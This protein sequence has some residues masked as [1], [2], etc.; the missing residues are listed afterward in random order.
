MAKQTLNEHLVTYYERKQLSELTLANLNAIIEESGEG[1]RKRWNRFR[2][3][4]P[5][6]RRFL[7]PGVLAYASVLI[8][9]GYIA[10][11]VTDEPGRDGVPVNL[12]KDIA[13]EIA[14]NHRKLLAVE[15][16]SETIPDLSQQMSKLD[17]SL[18]RPGRLSEAL[19]IVGARYC[20]IQGA[21]AAQIQLTDA[22]GHPYTLYQTRI[23]A[24]LTSIQEET[25]EFE[26]L[27]LKLWHEN[28]IFL[29]LA[30]PEA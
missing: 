6:L 18:I 12:S 30:G 28:G 8:L 5:P 24:P 11:M 3:S 13:R 9:L 16:I 17:F 10:W 27:Q 7:S 4:L 2:L 19:T 29:G 1:E 21:I 22:A 20:S 23:R 14:M 15:F 26:G 25:F